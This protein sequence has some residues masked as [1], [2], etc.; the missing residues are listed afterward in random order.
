MN[1]SN[2][3]SWVS[4]T[5]V[6]IK[7]KWVGAFWFYTALCSIIVRGYKPVEFGKHFPQQTKTIYLYYYLFNSQFFCTLDWTFPFYFH[8]RKER[9]PAIMYTWSVS[10]RGMRRYICIESPKSL[11]CTISNSNIAQ[12]EQYWFHKS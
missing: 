6:W 4:L 11:H 8:P 12:I 1:S 5:R 2:S 10:L 9:L 7:G 3:N